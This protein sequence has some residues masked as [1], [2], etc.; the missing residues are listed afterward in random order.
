MR[1]DEDEARMGTELEQS[2]CNN[3]SLGL[4]GL[5]E[6]PGTPLQMSGWRSPVRLGG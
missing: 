2:S 3:Q 5:R 6:Q 4:L 1:E